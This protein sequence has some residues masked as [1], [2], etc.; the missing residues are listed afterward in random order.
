MKP[1]AITLSKFTHLR[2]IVVICTGPASAYAWDERA[3]RIVKETIE[4]E[5][6]PGRLSHLELQIFEE[7]AT[8]TEAYQKKGCHSYISSMDGE[9]PGVVYCTLDGDLIRVSDMEETENWWDLDRNSI[10]WWLE[11]I[12]E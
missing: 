9:D 5:A 2:H 3:V 1:M 4:E 10:K 6:S 8:I 11:M 12:A 7:H